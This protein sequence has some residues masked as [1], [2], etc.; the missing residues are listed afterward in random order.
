MSP[1]SG[2]S[3]RLSIEKIVYPGRR[4]A[5]LDGRVFF[6]DDGLPGET[7]EAEILKERSS[8]VEARTTAILTPSPRRIP[9]RCGH[10]LAC[11][12][13]QG[14]PYA[15]Q[16]DLKK[17][18]FREMFRAPGL[19]L[20]VEIEIVSSPLEWHYRNK[21]RFSLRG[22]GPE[23]FLAY[24]VPGSHD[25]FLPTNNRC[26]LATDQACAIA[27][28]VLATVRECGTPDLGEIEVRESRSEG[29]FLLNLFWRTR[30][31]KECLD[32][33]LAALPPRFPLSGIVSWT[34]QKGRR[35]A[36]L[37]E[38]GSDSIAERAGET[39]YEI[40]A[41]SFFQ[42]NGA[43]LPL[44]LDAIV[45]AAGLRGTE[46]VADV[47]GGVGTFGLALSKS[48]GRVFVVE[49]FPDNIRRL[50]SNISKNGLGNVEVCPG[51]GEEWMT[52]LAGRGLDLVVLDPPR[53]GLAPEV[54]QALNEHSVGKILYLSCNPAT[55]ARD[56]V[57]LGRK[58]SPAMVQLFD[59]FPQTPHIETLAVLVPN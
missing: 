49:S 50:R 9:A 58:Y 6:T 37:L 48:A 10:F 11:G 41:G 1:E 19:A 3:V 34:P 28:A 44:V 59:F 52:D 40:G 45:A 39:V 26:F 32:A 7:V 15:D 55:L 5:R 56:I 35:A 33:I 25:A 29:I 54:V 14:L 42:I 46:T 18:Q 53:K 24:H 51:P 4:L 21:I 2:R 43:I 16:L 57:L 30:R 27:G 23:T 22:S 38:W 20:P 47:Y 12:S 31:S 8:F 36:E 13:Y 17:A